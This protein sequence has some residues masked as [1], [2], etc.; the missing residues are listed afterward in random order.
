[1]ESPV[2]GL[3]RV[4]TRTVELGGTVI[5]EGA[6][7]IA[8]YASANRDEE[9]FLDGER[10]DVMR[11]NSGA[12]LAFGAGVHFC[13]GAMLGRQEMTSAFTQLLERLYDIQ[14]AVADDTLEH[15]PSLLHRRLKSLPVRFR[16]R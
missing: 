6:V 11:T 13:P 4:A 14:L 3:L 7:V 5:P 10:F 9:K 12:H 2:Q 15:H 16:P 1:M 8:R